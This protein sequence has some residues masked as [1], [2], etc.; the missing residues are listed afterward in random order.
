MQKI[1]SIEDAVSLIKDGDVVWVNGFLSIA[2]PDQLNRQITRSFRATGHPCHLSVYASAGFA[3]W[4]EGS[5][6]EGYITDGAVDRV[7]L[8]HYGS[9]T[10]TNRMIMDVSKSSGMK[11]TSRSK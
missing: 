9:M 2:T 7:V 11:S 6:I 1:C 8:G 3:E 10:G 5:E 4:R